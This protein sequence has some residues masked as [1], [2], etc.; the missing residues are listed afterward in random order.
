MNLPLLPLSPALFGLDLLAGL[1]LDLLFGDPEGFPH[2]IRLVGKA[3]EYGEVKF[4]KLPLGP[5][6]QGA[7]LTLVILFFSILTPALLLHIAAAISTISVFIISSMIIY[8]TLAIRCLG[9]EAK[10]VAKALEQEGL[11]A[12]RKR[13]SRI[14]GRETSA[15]TESGVAAAAIESVAENLVDGFVSPFFFCALGGPPMA[16]G[17]KAVNTLDS[18]IGYKNTKYMDFGKT[19]AK[20]DDLCNYVPARLTVL[21]VA[22]VSPLVGGPS[23]MEVVKKGFQDGKNHQSPN[24]GL[25]EASFAWVLGTRLSGPISYEGKSENRPFMNHEGKEPAA[26]DIFSAVKLMYLS[27]AMG[28][29]MILAL[30]VSAKAIFQF[31]LT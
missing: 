31:F 1:L 22:L 12:A 10:A 29:V 17:Y 16:M 9:E 4:R 8:Y 18:M 13:V 25:P 21:A 2:P 28:V 6:V 5:A 20:L 30:V 24:A 7:L 15:L 11:K 26:K 27:G 19:A 14:V 3:I 23:F